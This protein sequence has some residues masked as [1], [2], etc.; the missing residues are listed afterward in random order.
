MAYRS[1]QARSWIG[2]IAAGLHH[3]QSN[4]LG[5][6]KASFHLI[7]HSDPTS[8]LPPSLDAVFLTS[9][10]SNSTWPLKRFVCNSASLTASPPGNSKQ[11]WSWWYGCGWGQR[12]TGHL[13]PLF[14]FFFFF[15][16]YGHS[17]AR[18]QIGAAVASLC[19]SHSNTRFESHLW[20]TLQFGVTPDS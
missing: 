20:P 6:S 9:C 3:S 5:G 15:R 4:E 1:S 2:A 11:L 17:Q 8:P 12:S 19:H 10:H 16:A 14:F 18:G 7:I 13:W